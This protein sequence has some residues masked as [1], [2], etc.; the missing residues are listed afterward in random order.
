MPVREGGYR[1]SAGPRGSG[2]LYEAHELIRSGKGPGRHFALA[3]WEIPSKGEK[4][5][6]A[7]AKK[8]SN[9]VLG[10]LLG[11]PDAG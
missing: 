2:F 6:Y 3:F 8:F 4:V 11:G 9:K 5:R 7:L 1:S 10:I